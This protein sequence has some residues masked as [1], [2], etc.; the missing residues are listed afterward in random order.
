MEDLE[1]HW[2]MKFFHMIVFLKPKDSEKVYLK[3]FSKS[4]ITYE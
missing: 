4:D 3:S 1:T 2:K